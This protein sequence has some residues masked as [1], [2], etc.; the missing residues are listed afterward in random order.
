MVWGKHKRNEH[1]EIKKVKESKK[2]KDGN[3]K[4]GWCLMAK[5]FSLPLFFKIHGPPC[6]GIA[7][8]RSGRTLDMSGRLL[9]VWV[10][11]MGGLP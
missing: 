1:G 2:S 5:M 8:V 4:R 6:I 10:G 11:G 7:H 9:T 3:Y